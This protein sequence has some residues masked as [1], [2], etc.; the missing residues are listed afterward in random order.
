MSRD[1][2]D[3]LLFSNEFWPQEPKSCDSRSQCVSSRLAV[4]KARGTG[5]FIHFRA[6]WGTW[7]ESVDCDCY[8]NHVW[9]SETVLLHR[10]MPHFITCIYIFLNHKSAL[11][12]CMRCYAK[13]QPV[14]IL[15]ILYKYMRSSSYVNKKKNIT[16]Q[17]TVDQK[18]KWKIYGI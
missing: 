3:F 18:W 11:N 5:S 7:M 16:L 9:S 6:V 10:G 13:H 14:W 1:A 8:L 15:N 2:L 17:V 4:P 12:N